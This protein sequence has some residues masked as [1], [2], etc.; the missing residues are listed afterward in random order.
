MR[1]AKVFHNVYFTLK[2]FDKGR[3]LKSNYDYEDI[4]EIFQ[5][6][7]FDKIPVAVNAYRNEFM[8]DVDKAGNILVGYISAYYP[9]DRTFE[10]MILEKFADRIAQ[11]DNP[12]IYPRV[13][14]VNGKAVQILG[15][16]ICSANY[17]AAISK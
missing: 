9:E 14:V 12:I 3:N 4:D 10:V 7:P 11:Y 5:S 8:N 13:K 2:V 15:L 1:Q 16:D 17:Y 6:V